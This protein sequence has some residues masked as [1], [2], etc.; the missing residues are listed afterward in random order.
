MR[1]RPWIEYEVWSPLPPAQ[2]VA[3]L[4]NDVGPENLR[5]VGWVKPE[6]PFVGKVFDSGFKIRLTPREEGWDPEA[7]VL[8]PNINGHFAS[9]DRGTWIQVRLTL[10]L[11][12]AATL[13]LP[14]GLIVH[15]ALVNHSAGEACFGVFALGCF[16]YAACKGIEKSRQWL[17]HSLHA[18]SAPPPSPRP[19]PDRAANVAHGLDGLGGW[20]LA[21]WEKLLAAA[22][23][24]LQGS[25]FLA[26][27]LDLPFQAA[28]QRIACPATAL[29]VWVGIGVVLRR[30]RG[31]LPKPFFPPEV[32]QVLDQAEAG[33]ATAQRILA[34]HYLAG[35]GG[36]PR[37]GREA[38]HWL[39]K[40]AEGGDPKAACL[41]AQHLKDGDAGLRD[42]AEARRWL[43]RAAAAGHPLAAERLGRWQRG[44][45]EPHARGA[46]PAPALEPPFR[47][48]EVAGQVGE[49]ISPLPLGT[50]LPL[51]ILGSLAML[52][53]G[54]LLLV[55]SFWPPSGTRTWLLLLGTL[56]ALACALLVLRGQGTRFQRL[57]RAAEAG[58]P[59]AQWRL[60]EAYLK[61]THGL[62]R[63]E[64]QSLWWLLR[65]AQGGDARA[66]YETALR[67]DRGQGHPR[68][69]AAAKDWLRRSAAA[70]YGPAQ[71]LLHLWLRTPAEP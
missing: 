18:E 64:S 35:A 15:G 65:C 39:R 48:Q 44:E 33:D 9:A 41:L 49:R 12:H 69:R 46:M 68:D 43:D 5:L 2:L 30:Y 70:G 47:Y 42:E 57:V 63:D 28:L 4:R 59:Q 19:G 6:K 34:E 56:G 20:V 23:L 67:L 8:F 61:A 14:L 52:L 13:L 71:H 1:S 55:L 51:I 60:S 11:Y 62:A 66:A 26:A 54:V 29:W 25:W 24:L 7:C 16:V 36:L 17:E 22:L 31:L 45:P 21:R 38:L 40:A 3:L 50:V 37:S 58:D 27:V 32:T 53:G 10:P